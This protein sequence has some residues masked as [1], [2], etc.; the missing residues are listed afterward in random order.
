MIVQCINIKTF[1]TENWPKKLCNIEITIPT[2]WKCSWS[3]MTHRGISSLFF[4]HQEVAWAYI[5]TD[6]SDLLSFPFFFNQNDA[7]KKVTWKCR[8][9]ST[10]K[11]K[12]MIKTNQKKSIGVYSYGMFYYS[13]VTSPLGVWGEGGVNS[14][15]RENYQKLDKCVSYPSKILTIT[16]MFY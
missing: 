8:I 6:W 4:S 12:Q 1:S 13:D 15:E 7:R 14:D 10:D 3:M 11:S 16:E 5:A 2:G 9:M